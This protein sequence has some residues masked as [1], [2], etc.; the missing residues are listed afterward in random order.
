MSFF[1][2]FKTTLRFLTGV[3]TLYDIRQYQG[4]V[5]LRIPLT[6]WGGGNESITFSI[7]IIF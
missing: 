7:V 4:G 3:Y 1:L 2:H 5:F 6:K